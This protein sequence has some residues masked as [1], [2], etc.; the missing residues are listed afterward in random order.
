MDKKHNQ[1][2]NK[3]LIDNEIP[4][5]YYCV[6]SKSHKGMHLGKLLYPSKKTTAKKVLF[7]WWKGWKSF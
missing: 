7:F 3:F 2:K 4:I 6:K 1:C 5:I